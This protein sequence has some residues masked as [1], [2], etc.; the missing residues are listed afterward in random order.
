MAI[1][2]SE[3]IIEI[4]NLNTVLGGHTIHQNLN[5]IIHRHEI[6]GLIGNSGSGK[7]TLMRAMLLLNQSASGSIRIFGHDILTSQIKM[8]QHFGV[9][10]QQGALFSSMSVLENVCFP[11]IEFTHLDPETSREIAL[12]QLALTKFPLD[13][14][15]LYPAVLSGGMMKRAALARAIVLNPEILFL[16][17]PTAGLDPQTAN[18]LDLLLLH[19]RDSLGLTIIM[20]T[21]D[22]DTLWRITDRV[23]FLGEKR[24]LA[25]DTIQQ[26]SIHPH[27]ELQAYFAGP[28]G[29]IG[30]V[31]PQDI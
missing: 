19:L 4:N 3:P 20:I 13:L 15:D 9:M 1:R 25:I 24:V 16:D 17:E 10:F 8:Q 31:V 30:T 28:R 7:T 11:L 22:V 23:A 21:H 18:N 26:L 6:L 14:V 5:L 27:P 2:N 29:K 12:Y